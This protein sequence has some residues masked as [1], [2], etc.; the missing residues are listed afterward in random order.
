MS[1]DTRLLPSY[2]A[3]TPLYG[4]MCDAEELQIDSLFRVGKYDPVM[5]R[6]F[7]A[8][9]DE[10]L[11]SVFT[12]P[13]NYLLWQRPAFDNETISQLLRSNETDY[14]SGFAAIQVI[15]FNPAITLF[16]LLRLFNPGRLRCGDTYVITCWTHREQEKWESLAWHR[17]SRM[18]IDPF[19]P[20]MKD[21][22][23]SF[24]SPDV[25]S[26]NTFQGKLQPILES[27]HKSKPLRSLELAL[28][29]YAREEFED[30]DVVNLLTALEALLANDNTSGPTNCHCV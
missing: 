22:T 14:A 11:K 18:T 26:F 9:E 1:D 12:L 17:C 10:F 5:T 13:P 15:F 29:L 21:A 28:D 19:V 8:A 16:R 27:I 25:P 23:F 2:L 7:F 24:N 3:I 20:F 30:A 4:F 6:P